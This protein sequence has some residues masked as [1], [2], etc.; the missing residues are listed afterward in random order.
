MSRTFYIAVT[1]QVLLFGAETWMFT[2]K[3]E[4]A[5]DA[6]QG[7]VARN[8]TGRQPRRGRDGRWSY[9]SL[10]GAIKEAGIVRIWTSILRRQITVAQ[11]IVTRPILDLC[12]KA[13]RRTGARVTRQWWEKTRI[14]WKGAR[15][16]A[17]AAEEAAEPALT[18]TDSESEAD[19]HTTDGTARGTGEVASLGA[20]GFS[21]AEWSRSED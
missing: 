11:F 15:E 14:D 5:L 8:L 21:G 2:K 13:V 20:S 4:L 18:D 3:M 17:E 10:A 1:Q 9:P 12:E 16:K 6:F 19:A 7:R